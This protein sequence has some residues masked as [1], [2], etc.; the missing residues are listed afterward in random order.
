MSVKVD[1]LVVYSEEMDLIELLIE[2]LKNELDGVSKEPLE[3]E[4][5]RQHIDI[6]YTKMREDGR[7]ICGFSVQ[8]DNGLVE[9]D[10]ASEDMR[11]LIREFSKSVAGCTNEGIEH[12]LKL[13][14]F[15]LQHE[16][17]KYGKE[18]FE[19]E[20][21]LRE[22]LS[23]IFVDTYGEDFYKLLKE[24]SV[25]PTGQRKPQESQ[26]Q[27][28]YENQLFF[29]E[30]SDYVNIN[31]RKDLSLGRIKEYMGQSEDFEELKRRITT[32]P[33]IKEEY[34]AFLT[35]LQERLDPIEKLR[36]C[37]AHNRSIPKRTLDNYKTAKD[38]LLE[39]IKE[40]LEELEDSEM[41]GE[42]ET[43]N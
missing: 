15:Q 24:V 34:A 13:N 33:I 39:E 14:D 31:V 36:N 43:G 12:L 21:N 42:T 23:L 22:A 18:I 1:Y 17:R 25:E 29:L 8:F 37:V 26:M 35:R 41:N 30:F 40:F 32:N 28:Q 6:R 20:M 9:F 19:I 16:L 4:E 27:A 5:L 38:L 7:R 11:N 10:S 3:T 2:T